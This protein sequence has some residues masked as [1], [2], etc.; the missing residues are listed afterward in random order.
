MPTFEQQFQA[1][2]DW[3]ASPAQGNRLGFPTFMPRKAT[4]NPNVFKYPVA[5]FRDGVAQRNDSQRALALGIDPN[6]TDPEW[7]RW[8]WWFTRINM[9]ARGIRAFHGFPTF[10]RID[11]SFG[12]K[13]SLVLINAPIPPAT[14]GVSWRD[15]P[16]RSLFN[17]NPILEAL[18]G[19]T[20]WVNNSPEEWLRAANAWALNND[21]QAS[22]FQAAIPTGWIASPAGTWVVGLVLF[23]GTAV[24]LVDVDGTELFPEERCAADSSYTPGPTE[25]APTGGG[26][27]FGSGVAT[28]AAPMDQAPI[29]HPLSS[30]QPQIDYLRCLAQRKEIRVALCS[31]DPADQAALSLT[32]RQDSRTLVYFSNGGAGGAW[33]V[34]HT[35]DPATGNSTGE[36]ASSYLPSR[37]PEKF[38]FEVTPGAAIQGQVTAHSIGIVKQGFLGAP[39]HVMSFTWA[40]WAGLSPGMNIGIRWAGS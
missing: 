2:S 1:V 13:L 14:G 11:H 24:E 15:V 6:H 16:A 29:G 37:G 10:H 18:L 4:P 5:I 7:P 21:L 36:V 23:D 8:R 19:P 35:M 3:L 31:P 39:T 33:L 12:E 22:D 40:T 30:P 26:G 20:W 34:A 32:R 25:C 17:A 38:A 28:P 27:L 9:Y